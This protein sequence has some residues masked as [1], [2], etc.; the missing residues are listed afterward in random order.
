MEESK[1]DLSKATVRGRIPGGVAVVWDKKLDAMI[2]PI[3]LDVL[4]YGI[5]TNTIILLFL[6]FILH[7]SVE[8]MRLNLLIDWLLLMLLSK[9]IALAVYIL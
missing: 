5:L 4:V 8:R 1:T 9:A 7:M 3:R 6:M 2:K